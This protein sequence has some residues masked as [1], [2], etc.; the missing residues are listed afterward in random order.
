MEKDE[1]TE[2]IVIHSS[3]VMSLMMSLKGKK[4]FF[5]LQKL[6][7]NKHILRIIYR[8]KPRSFTGPGCFPSKMA[9]TEF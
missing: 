3:H 1:D 9:A 8:S 2:R 4:M 6:P 5:W 7:K